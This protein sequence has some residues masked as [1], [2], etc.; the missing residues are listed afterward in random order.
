MH[1]TST[2]IEERV[3]DCYR[4]HK[5]AWQI[6]YGDNTTSPQGRDFLFAYIPTDENRTLFVVRG[7][8]IRGDRRDPPSSGAHKFLLFANPVRNGVNGKSPIRGTDELLQWLERQGEQNGF[9]L[10]AVE[11][12]VDMPRPFT[13]E[14]KTHYKHTVTYRGVLEVVD[15]ESFARAYRAGIGPGRGFGFGML[16]LGGAA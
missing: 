14:D 1:E 4:A 6:A 7:E 2:T 11:A 3:F 12:R 5:R 16:V 13:K 15:A 9:R 8:H 10:K